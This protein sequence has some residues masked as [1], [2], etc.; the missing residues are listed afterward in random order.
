MLIKPIASDTYN[1]ES[2]MTIHQDEIEISFWGDK[3]RR[4]GRKK[5]AGGVVAVRGRRERAGGVVAVRGRREK[6]N[7]Q[8][9]EIVM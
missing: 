5:R 6:G 4:A 3:G 1:Y 9:D 8:A 7:G 2:K